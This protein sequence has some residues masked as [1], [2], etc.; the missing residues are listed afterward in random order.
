[1]HCNVF[2]LKLSVVSVLFQSGVSDLTFK[3]FSS[4]YCKFDR[5][6]LLVVDCKDYFRLPDLKDTEFICVWVDVCGT[7]N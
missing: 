5:C 7:A 6:L 4:L 3:C 2:K 1:M